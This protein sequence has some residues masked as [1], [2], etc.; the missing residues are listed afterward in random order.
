MLQI[1]LRFNQ[2]EDPWGFQHRAAVR[3]VELGVPLSVSRLWDLRRR[4]G[5]TDSEERAAPAALAHAFA[6][7]AGAWA[8][9]VRAGADPLALIDVLEIGADSPE[10]AL[11]FLEAA[12]SGLRYLLTSDDG[13]AVGSWGRLPAV[14]EAVDRGA[15]VLGRWDPLHEAAPDLDA[16]LTGGPLVVVSQGY[17]G[18]VPSDL[19][20]F[21][22]G[23]VR[24]LL[25][26]LSAPTRVPDPP[27]PK[28]LPRLALQVSWRRWELPPGGDPRVQALADRYARTLDG[29]VLPIPVGA[30]RVRYRLA[31]LAPTVL[32]LCAE[33]GSED[34]TALAGSRDVGTL[35]VEVNLD[36]LAEACD[37]ALHG[38]PRGD[39]AVAALW[40][41]DTPEARPA[42]TAAF[43]AALGTPGLPASVSETWAEVLRTADP[44]AVARVPEEALT[45]LAAASPSERADLGAALGTAWDRLAALAGDPTLPLRLGDALRATGRTDE[46]ASC[47]R[48]GLSLQGAS[49]AL[50]ARLAEIE[51]EAATAG[52]RSA[53]AQLP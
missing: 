31:V 17:L 12:P 53:R 47:Y 18:W 14:I 29:R 44:A 34:P 38:R 43:R 50:A 13:E 19:F 33:D 36:A 24:E 22:D 45:A 10:P 30:L 28:D 39:V 37:G 11:A 20:A 27:R 3:A 26:E 16:P 40:L 46:A 48:L 2:R 4:A 1:R 7:V 42:T 9:E 23:V 32:L 8:S 52:A 21:E 15:L 51:R 5:G 41:G 35:D 25:V 49:P 6:A